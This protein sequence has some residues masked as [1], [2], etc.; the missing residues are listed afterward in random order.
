MM[1][2]IGVMMTVFSVM[3]TSVLWEKKCE[4]NRVFSNIFLL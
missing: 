2:A 1:T 4:W 3:M